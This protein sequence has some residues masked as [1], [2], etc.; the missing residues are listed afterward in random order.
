M[1]SVRGLRKSYPHAGRSTVALDGVD[2]QVERGAFATVLGPSG[3]G[4]TTLLRC[5]AG[6]ETPDAGTITLA[7]RGLN[8]AR[9]SV[10]PYERRV[11]IVPQ[12]G[13]LFP[14]LSVARNIAFGLADQPKPVRQA[15]VEELLALVDLAG[16]ADRRPHQLSGGQQ[17]RVALARALAPEP[18]LILLDEPFSALDAHL[19]ADL[20]EEVRE[21]LRRL[22]TTALLVTHDQAEAMAL[23]DH[24]IVMRSGRVVSAGDPREVYD[25]PADAELGR[26][27]GE[28]SM[29]VG[30][31]ESGNGMPLVRCALGLLP[32]ATHDLRPGACEV[33]IRS[34][35]LRL[36][37]R[38]GDATSAIGS[39]GLVVS[40]AFSGHDALVRV[41]LE[42]GSTVSVRV[43]G[44]QRYDERETV[45]V[46]SEGPV[47]AY[48][49]AD[50]SSAEE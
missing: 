39:N 5:I 11:G 29:L 34:E 9:A 28:S 2:V 30:V 23:A 10:P 48:P 1:L 7:G 43:P 50:R 45:Q 12:E 49:I 35:N 6:F 40:Q 33:L 14:H 44:S 15:R 24:L 4:K 17:Q 13:A 19:R 16:F 21:V 31:I 47:S 42:S 8:D 25:A 3:S 32:L 46:W 27:L 18:Q 22:D 26:F 20:R 38:H 37:A 41:M 36:Q